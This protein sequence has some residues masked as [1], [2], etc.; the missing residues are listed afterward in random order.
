MLMKIGRTSLLF[1]GLALLA[2]V[3]L[4]VSAGPARAE[5][6]PCG[7]CE[8]Y[9][10][11][12]W[13][14]HYFPYGGHQGGDFNC[15]ENGCHTGVESGE[16]DGHGHDICDIGDDASTAVIEALMHAAP[17]GDLGSVRA[18]LTDSGLVLVVNTRRSALQLT[19]V[20]DP[21]RVVVSIPLQTLVP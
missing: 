15:G 5:E 7:D 18:L 3:I 1:S 12:Y 11:I 21:S 10:Y 13:F 2:V 17:T 20:C 14:R 9:W 16:C 8:D 6:E 4:L 19:P